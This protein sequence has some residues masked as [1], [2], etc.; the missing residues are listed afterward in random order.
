M[1]VRHVVSRSLAGRGPRVWLAIP[2]DG[3]VQNIEFVI[4]KDGWREADPWSKGRIYEEIK[5]AVKARKAKDDVFG[6]SK[7][8]TASDIEEPGFLHRTLAS[9]VKSVLGCKSAVDRIHHR[10]VLHTVGKPLSRFGSTFE[11]MVVIRDVAKSLQELSELGINHQDI[12]ANNI[13]INASPEGQESPRGLLIDPE[14][15]SV[16][17]MPDYDNE[18]KFITGTFQFLS[19]DR[20]AENGT[21]H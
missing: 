8:F 2:A 9:Q 15:A 1:W 5:K 19:I 17:G 21:P 14:L 3:D 12:S 6:L 18:L 13:L 16:P 10:C 20:L 11:L 7:C 4:I